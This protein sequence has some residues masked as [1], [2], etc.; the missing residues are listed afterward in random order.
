MATISSPVFHTGCSATFDLLSVK[1]LDTTAFGFYSDR[2]ETLKNNTLC[3]IYIYIYIYIYITYLLKFI[4]IVG[5][6]DL[7]RVLWFINWL[8]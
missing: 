2:R 8:V 4:N 5:T 6:R 7:G 1:Y 3:T